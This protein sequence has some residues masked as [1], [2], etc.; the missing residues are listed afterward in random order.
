MWSDANAPEVGGLLNVYTVVRLG[1]DPRAST[2]PPPAPPQDSLLYALQRFSRI[3]RAPLQQR[4]VADVFP[5]FYRRP[6]SHSFSGTAGEAMSPVILPV[7]RKEP[8]QDL[9]SLDSAL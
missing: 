7:A 9:R 1:F 6:A 8:S 4:A 2:S 5:A 3:G